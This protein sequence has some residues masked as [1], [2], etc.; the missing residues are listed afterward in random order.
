[1][2][3][4]GESHVEAVADR[5]VPR[6]RIEVVTAL[7]VAGLTAGTALR[8]W[9][10]L[11]SQGALDADEAV[12]GLMAMHVLHGQV[13]TFF[14]GQAYGGS[15][16]TLVTA[17]LFWIFGRSTAA[18]K[19]TPMLFWAVAT[20]LVW[21]VG[22]RTLGEPRARLA[23][24]LFWMW[25]VFFV[26]KSTRAHGFYGAGLVFGLWAMLAALRLRERPTRLDVA[27]LGLAL[28]L[29]WWATPESAIL[30]LPAVGWLL[31][32]RPALV[33]R[34]PLAL[35]AS[36]LG[37]LPW[38]LYNARLGWPSL[39]IAH[40]YSSKVDHARNLVS[41]TLPAALGLRLPFSLDWFP[42]VVV[43]VGLYAAA[44]AGFGLL[45]LRRPARLGLLLTAALVFPVL[46]VASPYT[47]YTATPR[48]FTLAVPVVVLLTAYGACNSRRSAA[49][50][51]VAAAFSFGGLAVMVHRNLA[52]SRTEGVALPADFGA[53]LTTLEAHRVRHVWA[54]YWIG[55]RLTFE[56]GERIVAAE[57]GSTRLAV[58]D[59]RVVQ[60]GGTAAEP[61]TNGRYAPY[62][63]EVADSRDD[64]YVV[65]AQ[66]TLAPLWEPVLRR[67]RYVLVRVGAFDVWLPPT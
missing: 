65:M 67:A 19:A 48:Y 41:S 28:G 11:S 24:A 61:A 12:W 10:M 55:Y 60:V 42:D 21:R 64:A 1:M 57:P 13:P 44:A 3:V 27:S 63:L 32:T 20:V 47:W 4:G 50:L 29:G 59:G 38:W 33:R 18:L 49:M 7:T 2:T 43:G 22:R 54:T 17:A 23:A 5:S 53:L 62:Q 39:S 52:A 45:L 56:S 8:V 15:Q 30:T 51:A 26:W 66:G 37:S 16:E 25:P 34:A 9:I 35:A 36:G 58:Q 31:W 46:Y 40:D 14:W 6:V